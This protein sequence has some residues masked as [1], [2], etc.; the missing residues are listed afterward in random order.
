MVDAATLTQRVLSWQLSYRTIT[1]YHNGG[2]RSGIS[3]VS[4]DLYVGGASVSMSHSR[5][6]G[7]VPPELDERAQ[8]SLLVQ[9]I[10]KGNKQAVEEFYYSYYDR[11]Y[12]F[13]FYQVGRDHA[14]AK[15]VLQDT[16]IAALR[17]MHT[18]RGDSR[19]YAWLC[20]VAW[21]KAADLRR[22]EHR[23]AE[24]RKGFS[25]KSVLS[26]AG[27]VSRA[28]DPLTAQ[29]ERDVVRRA[30]MELPLRYREV[31]VFRYVEG[32]SVREIARSTHRSFKSVESLITQAR[33][34][35]RAAVEVQELGREVES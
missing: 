20:G 28:E 8:E 11:L 23:R 4:D 6:G 16:F 30:M 21:R 10:L 26:A 33:K 34:A 3:L 25:E 17:S 29:E 31:L 12:S 22:R 18:F 5:S 1:C 2:L 19:L 27:L 14:D 35:F 7:A 13:V 9:R 15:D 24:M 32:F